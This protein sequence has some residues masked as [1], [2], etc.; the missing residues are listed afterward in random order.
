MPSIILFTS[1]ETAYKQAHV[2][3]L[4]QRTAVTLGVN[5][6]FSPNLEF[7]LFM[8]KHYNQFTDNISSGTQSV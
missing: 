5:G 4:G 1:P 8:Q 6:V 3:G 7:N 2:F